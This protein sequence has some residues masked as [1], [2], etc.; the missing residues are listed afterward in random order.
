MFETADTTTY[1]FRVLGLYFV[2]AGIGVMTNMAAIQKIVDEVRD[3]ALTRFIAGILA[4][5][6]GVVV[7]TLHND[8]SNWQA[9]F[10]TF[11]GW[12]A[13]IKGLLII[14]LPLPVTSMMAAMTGAGI[15]RVWGLLVILA[16]ALMLW[17]GF[18]G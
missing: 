15:M 2:A 13:L 3:N 17:L 11:F 14:A 16:G 1:F 5:S 18:G 10:V 4:F 6:F 12:A 8:W 9:G 7:L